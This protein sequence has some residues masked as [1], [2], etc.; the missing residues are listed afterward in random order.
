MKTNLTCDEWCVIIYTLCLFLIIYPV[1]YSTGYTIYRLPETVRGN[2]RCKIVSAKIHRNHPLN[3]EFF[4]IPLIFSLISLCFKIFP[5]RT[6]RFSPEKHP[7]SP[8]ETVLSPGEIHVAP[9]TFWF[10][11]AEVPCLTRKNVF[12]SQCFTVFSQMNGK[13]PEKKI[14]SWQETFLMP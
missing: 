6:A 7:L 8:G 5:R 14:I 10:F 12:L 2:G 11:R 13:C 1:T 3:N 4:Q 9:G